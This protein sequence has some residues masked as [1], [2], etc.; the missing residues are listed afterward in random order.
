MPSELPPLQAPAQAARDT[1]AAGMPASDAGGSKWDSDE[2]IAAGGEIDSETDLFLADPSQEADVWWGAYAGRTMAPTFA[3]CAVLSL[4]ISIVVGWVWNEERLSAQLMWHLAVLMIIAVW[5][6][7]LV[8]WVYRTLSRN[9]RLTTRNLYRDS[10]FH[11]PAAGQ[12]ALARVT[13]V[14]VRCT[15][16]DRRLGVGCILLDAEGGQRL[17]LH[18]VR[19]PE[20]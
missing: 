15:A 16:L 20:R 12:V 5:F 13:R 14:E 10:G 18:G 9:Y 6:F 17:V 11:Q 2:V 7:P 8:L 1:T 4:N 3:L 19:D